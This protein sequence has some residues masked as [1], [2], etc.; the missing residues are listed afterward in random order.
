[1]AQNCTTRHIAT[2]SLT[3]AANDAAH[4]DILNKSYLVGVQFTLE[5]QPVFGA[6]LEVVRAELSFNAVYSSSTND[7]QGIIGNVTSGMA[8]NIVTA[9]GEPVIPIGVNYYMGPLYVL[10]GGT[11]VGQ[12][13]YINTSVSGTLTSYRVAATLYLQPA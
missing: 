1:M 6:A 7:S 5:V 8:I 2:S 12:R 13:L 10:I 11:P 4:I 9:A 3:L